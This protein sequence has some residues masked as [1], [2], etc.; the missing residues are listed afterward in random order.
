MKSAENG[1]SVA[2]SNLGML[3]YYGEGTSKDFKQALIWYSKVWN[4]VMQQ[5]NSTLGT[6]Y[7]NGEGTSID[8]KQA[9][10]WLLKKVLNKAML[11][12]NSTLE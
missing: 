10:T 5:L 9:F 4:K 1:N 6:T 3:Y 8:F 11:M 12:H 7:Y 2:Q